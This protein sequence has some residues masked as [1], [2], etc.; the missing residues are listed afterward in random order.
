MERINQENNI[1]LTKKS[2]D[3]LVN[4]TDVSVFNPLTFEGYQRQIDAQ[5]CESIM[6]YVMKN[7]H[8]PSAIICACNNYT[9]DC[10]MNIVDGQH[11][12]ESFRRIRAEH[13]DRY[14]Q[15]KDLE[16]PVVVMNNVGIL[17]EIDT[18]ININKKSK[19]VDTSLAYVLKNKLSN[20][21][22]GDMAMPKA[23]Y[24]A[25]EVAQLFDKE[26]GLDIWRYKISYEGNVK[27][28]D[29]L[30]SL[31]AFVRA[32]RV[33]VNAL[34]QMGIINL[35]WHSQD[36]VIKTN[37]IVRDLLYDIW[38]NIY[39]KWPELFKQGKG[40]R[41]IQGSIGYTAITRTLVRILREHPVTDMDSCKQLF[42]TSIMKINIGHER[43]T[44]TYSSFSSESGYKLVSD[45]LLK[46]I[47]WE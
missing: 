7:F 44:D 43:W 13:P 34:N 1:L 42:R 28:S 16:L 4:N 11:R 41:I 12:V 15:I 47:R 17:V 46:S 5:H 9:D 39:M 18:F 37:E 10:R 27:K 45:E 29:R 22:S 25:V 14:Q 26:D 38:N 40:S 2:V 8:L 31:N 19:K 3:W 24:V 6:S 20:P 36:D 32:T 33:F 30:I 35:N 21:E 23:E